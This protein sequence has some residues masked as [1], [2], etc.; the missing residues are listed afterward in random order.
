MTT[1]IFVPLMDFLFEKIGVKRSTPRCC[2]GTMQ[3]W[4]YLLK[5]DWQ[6]DEAAPVKSALTVRRGLGAQAKAIRSRSG[7]L[8]YDRLD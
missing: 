5:L 1:E 6:N 2:S 7:E 8:V 3:R 4:A